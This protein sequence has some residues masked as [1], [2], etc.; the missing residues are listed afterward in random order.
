M[1]GAVAADGSGSIMKTPVDGG[2]SIAV[3][4]VK[5]LSGH[6]TVDSSDVY[7]ADTVVPLDG[8]TQ[9]QTIYRVCK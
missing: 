8:G 6:L 9:M 4:K 5:S 7:F 2:V 3:A 1:C